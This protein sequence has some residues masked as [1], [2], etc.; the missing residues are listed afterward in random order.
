MGNEYDGGVA[1]FEF[2]EVFEAFLL[3]GCV[4]HG[5]HFVDEQNIA[6]G[7]DGDGKSEADLH[8]GRVVFELLVHEIMEAG[9][10]DDVV[11][12]GGGVLAVEAQQ[13]SIEVNIFAAGQLG[14][15]A[16]AKLDKGR[17]AAVYNHFPAIG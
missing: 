12:D 14:V 2:L 8:A 4:A 10:V 3:K 15:K 17:E 7:P 5:Q 1:L 16:D 9:E 13:C 6:F 11:V